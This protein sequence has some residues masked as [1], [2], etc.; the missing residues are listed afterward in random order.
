MSD[1]CLVV[2]NRYL[3]VRFDS[4][5]ALAILATTLFSLSGS[6]SSGLAAL[7]ITTAIGYTRAV[8]WTCRLI[9]Q[10]EV[11]LK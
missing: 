11:D 6:I 2:L 9:T 5:G 8:Y 10:L 4:L 1:V 3:L 7:T